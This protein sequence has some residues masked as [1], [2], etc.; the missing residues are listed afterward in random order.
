MVVISGYMP[1]E[2]AM[3]GVFSMKSDI[4]SFGVMVLEIVTGKKNRGFY[5]EELGLN[6]LGCVS[7]TA[8]LNPTG[9]PSLIV[10]DMQSFS[11]RG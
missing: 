4:Y 11:R 1:P 8:Q 2:Y 10:A 7:T 3:D 5:D 9:D 6:L